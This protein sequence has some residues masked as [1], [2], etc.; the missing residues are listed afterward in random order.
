MFVGEGPGA[1][2][3]RL[4]KAFVGRAG[5][6]LDKILAAVDLTRQEVYITNTV[7]CRPPGNRT[8]KVNEIRTC[9]P[10][11]N[12]HI[13]LIEPRI[14]VALGSTAARALISPRA[15]I[16]RLRGTWHEYRDIP[17]LPTFHPAALLRDPS[18]KRP[19]WEDFKKLRSRLDQLQ[20][21]G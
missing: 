4:G 8:P 18:K 10:Y 19:V 1:Q 16:T 7:L 2:E 5:Q 20:E 6:L 15:R 9:A 12:G 17:L 13:E 3:D 11:L 21:T 14:L